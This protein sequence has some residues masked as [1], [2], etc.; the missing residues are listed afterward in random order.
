MVMNLKDADLPEQ[1]LRQ[2]PEALADIIATAMDAIIA[3]DDAQRIVLFNAAAEKMFCCPAEEAM[4]NSVERF[5]PQRFRAGHSTRVRQFDRSG[6]TNRTLSG[7]GTLCGLRAT[8]EEFPIEASIS[9]VESAGKKFFTV[10]IRDITERQRAEEARFRHAAIVESSDDAIVSGN[11]DGIIVS[12]NAGAQNIYGHTEAEAIGKSITILV[13]PELP[14]EENK[15]LERLRRGGRIEHFETIRVTK[16]GKKINVSLSVSPIKDSSGRTVGISGTARDITERKLAEEALRKSEERLRLAHQAARIGTFERNI[17]TGVNTWT[18]ELEAM[19]G[20]PAGGFGGTQTAF[21]NLVHPDDRARVIE[22][23]NW[24]LNTGQ[25]TKGEWRVVWPDGS[26]HWIAGRWQVYMNESGQPV[27]MVG[28]NIDITDRKLAEQE[29]AKANERLHLALEAG[30]VG[31]WDYNLKTGK[32]VWFGETHAQ[33]GMAPDETPG[34]FEE[35]WDRIHKDD[36]EHL[37]HALRVARD[38]HEQFTEEFRVVWRDGTTRWVRSRG[39]FFYAANGEPERLLGLSVDIT[40]RKLAEETL[41]KS[42]ERFRLAAQAGKMYSFEW[43]VTTDRVVRSSEHVGVLGVKEPLRITHQQFMDKLHPDDRPKL[44][45]AIAGLNPENPTCNVSYRVLV[46]DGAVV[47]IRSNGRAFFDGEGRMLRLVGMVADVTDQKLAEEKLR[48]YEKAVEGSEEMI[49]V[50]DRDY[51]YLIANRQFLKMRNMTMEQVV[52]LSAEEVLSKGFFEGVVKARLDE[53]FQGNVV[54][55]ETKYTYP[56]IGERDVLISYFPIEGAN[57]IDRVACIVQDITER[58]RAEEALHESEER[59][60]LVA[61]AAPVM[62]WMSGVDKKPTYFNQLWLDFTGLSETD[63]LNGLTGTV[64]PEDYPHGLDLYCRA[65]DQRQPF[66][67]ECR[68]RRHDGE[69]RWMLDI[70]V[71][72]FHKDGSFAGYIGSCIDVTDRKLAEEASSGMTRKLVEAQEQERARI[73]RELHDDISQRLAML[74]AEL[75]RLQG[76]PFKIRSRVQELRKKMSEVSND[77]QTLSHDLHSS[78][79]EYLGVV[80]GM[81]SWCKEFGERR[82]MEIDCSHDVRSTLPAEIGLCLFRVLQEALHNAAK[83]SGVK[84]IEVDLHEEAGEIHLIVRDSGRGFDVEAV[85]Q[86]KGLGLTSMCERVRLVN[87]TIAI[88]SKPMGGTTIHVRVPFRSERVSQVAV[89]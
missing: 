78:Q 19:Y 8:G 60:R 80:A 67:K 84:R 17:R 53:C 77:V 50:V 41:R 79:L 23:D 75:E 5:I 21:E 81:K 22:L 76:N 58:K 56:E 37:Q 62:I 32:K 31:G 34:S 3:V 18:P 74:A 40:E 38:K 46:S 35:S 55:Y 6:I 11:L 54:R 26:V 29:L 51:R 49:C 10:V 68:L 82:K 13:P 87:G 27:R 9:K 69:Y 72:R 20:L 42:E 4:G 30:S 48:E 52:G 15:I 70:G 24:A 25:P 64:H 43:D 1:N 39:R 28:I 66:T 47:W 65:F 57:G 59:F 45:A 44:I 63:L 86:G 12:W 14:D 88:V 7:L 89:G 73:A 61:N 85:K 2:S 33:L 71:P 16:T 36:R 83:H